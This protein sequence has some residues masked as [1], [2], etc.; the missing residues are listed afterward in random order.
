MQTRRYL[1][2]L[3]PYL[4]KYKR[5]YTILFFCIGIGMLLN[6][7]IAWFFQN[8]TNNLLG[9]TNDGLVLFLVL[10]ISIIIVMML[11]NYINTFYVAKTTSLVKNDIRIKMFNHMIEFPMSFFDS[12]HSGEIQSRIQQDT[13]QLDGVLGHNIIQFVI[14]PV[15]GIVAFV[16]LSFIHLPMSLIA[17]T[18]GPLILLVSKMFGQTI[19]NNGVAIQNNLA[20][21]TQ[22][23]QEALSG[24]MITKV[25]RL[26]HE[27]SNKYIHKSE[28]VL[29]TQFKEARVSGVLQAISIGISYCSQIMIFAIGCFF[30]AN[31]DLRVGDLFAFIVLSQSLI[32]PFSNMG[33]LWSNLQRSLAAVVRIY[34]F[35][36]ITKDRF[37]I[38]NKVEQVPVAIEFKN[39][40]FSYNDSKK[41]LIDVNLKIKP[42]ERVAIIGESGS[43]K[44]TLLKVLLGL[45]HPTEGEVWLYPENKEATMVEG[46]NPYTSYVPQDYFL[47]DDSIYQNIQYGEL[48][49]TNDQIQYAANMAN[50]H[51][52]ILDLPDQYNF[53]V[54]ERGSKLSGG[55]RQ[56]ITLARAFIG[57][58]SIVVLDEATSALDVQTEEFIIKHILELRKD[59]SLIMITHRLSTAM[60]FDRIILMDNGC[61]IASGTHTE[62]LRTSDKYKKLFEHFLSTDSRP[63][64]YPITGTGN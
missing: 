54:G 40:S 3:F 34:D 30:V 13:E 17:L 49:A 36:N 61:L 29:N 33:H 28:D 46:I 47:F 27:I 10:G 51:P 41:V 52:F 6:L 25:L 18:L 42:G 50:A 9:G 37:V 58:H 12:N 23:L 19:R 60:N 15:S 35:L 4:K 26:E 44:S 38:K 45:Y 59:H 22:Q 64:D 63:V 2:F 20:K 56:R 31:G 43:G 32:T 7:A 24:H 62:L 48:N 57:N 53:R 14:L 21:L 55:Q 8:M 1:V 11:T 16:Y 5:E 39:V